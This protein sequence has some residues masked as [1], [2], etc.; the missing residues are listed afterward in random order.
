LRCC[1]AAVLDLTA[2]R[3]NSKTAAQQ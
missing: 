1:G 3:Q 2:T